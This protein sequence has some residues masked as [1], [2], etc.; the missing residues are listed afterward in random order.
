L[1]AHIIVERA[2]TDMTGLAATGSGKC[3]IL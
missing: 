3:L 1:G 2:R